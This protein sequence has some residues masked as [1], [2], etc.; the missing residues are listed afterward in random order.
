MIE[1]SIFFGLLGLLTGLG[2]WLISAEG[3]KRLFFPLTI[4]GMTAG[5]LTGLF[6]NYA[7]GGLSVPL[8]AVTFPVIASIFT[9]AVILLY[10]P[11]PRISAK[12][13]DRLAKISVGIFIALAFFISFTAIPLAGVTVAETENYTGITAQSVE[14]MTITEEVAKT[15]AQPPTNQIPI[16]IN[17]L[18]STV[19]LFSTL[20][21]GVVGKYLYFKITFTVSK[22]NWVKPYVKIL[23]FEDKD[24]NGEISRGDT[25][26]KTTNYKVVTSQGSWRAN[27]KYVNGEPS[28]EIFVVRW[29]GE[30]VYLP[31]IHG[32]VTRWKDDTQYTF[33]NTPE[34]YK[35]PNDM[36][37]WNDDK[38]MET[39]KSFEV[40]PAGSSETIEGKIFCTKPGK[41]LMLV[42]AFDARY[43]DPFEHWFNDKPIAK[44]VIPF[45]VKEEQKP[46][47]TI[48]WT[49]GLALAGVGV[50]TAFLVSRRW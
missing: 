19:S 32:D 28:Q 5:W 18:K 41:Y 31:I 36:L 27:V 20:D 11:P 24:E 9:S 37:S 23:I 12:V 49:I 34:G 45:E 14:T 8:Y 10:L 30:D 1:V 38:L 48:D 26:Y 44:K 13:S 7:T 43:C 50:P 46:E 21:E 42:E 25:L 6:W 35:P 4:V 29:G 16:E 33:S 17:A 22:Y 2:M 47:I 3:D 15:L 39:I 40:I